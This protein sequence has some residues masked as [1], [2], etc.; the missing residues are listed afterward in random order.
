MNGN[1]NLRCLPIKFK[2]LN[3]RGNKKKKHR[4][5]SINSVYTQITVHTSISIVD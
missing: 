2:T 4:G 3:K 5:H 1:K